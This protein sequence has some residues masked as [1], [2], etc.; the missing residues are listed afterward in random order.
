MSACN[1]ILGPN[2]ALIWTD[3]AVFNMAG[4]IIEHHRKTI[5]IEG[6]K[7]VVSVCG[8]PFIAE[9]LAKEIAHLAA[10]IGTTF[11][12]IITSDGA[13]VDEVFTVVAPFAPT[14]GTLP[15]RFWITGWS[16]TD[17][18]PKCLGFSLEDGVCVWRPVESDFAPPL[19]EAALLMIYGAV[20]Q[21]SRPG[22]DKR[23]IG[24]PL[25]QAQRASLA[26]VPQTFEGPLIPGGAILETLITAEG[27]SQTVV[28]TWAEDLTATRPASSSALGRLISANTQGGQVAVLNRAARRRAERFDA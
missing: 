23:T 8:F 2:R 25:M 22:F 15:R 18:C 17:G 9:F 11:D 7:A 20:G 21:A 16:E 4:E 26:E 12:D 27:V 24:V 6:M 1:L 3:S 28:S 5:P 14:L 19:G 13:L 10:E